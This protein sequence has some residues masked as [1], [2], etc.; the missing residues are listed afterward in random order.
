MINTIARLLTMGF[1]VALTACSSSD[2]ANDSDGRVL[3]DPVNC[4]SPCLLET[5]TLDINTISAATGGTVNVT[6]TIKGDL[7]AI[8]QIQIDLLPVDTSSGQGRVTWATIQDPAQATI[9][10]PM[11]VSAGS[12]ASGNYYLDFNFAPSVVNEFGEGDAAKYDLLP[13]I[14]TTNY[15][16]EEVV[17]S[18]SQIAVI[19]DLVIPFITI[20]P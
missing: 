20:N 10:Q 14:S 1:L 5:P 6:F 19:T 3:S 16:F 4:N 13:D 12:I 8:S 18:V 17:A 15:S 11:V 9:T 7:A 2:T